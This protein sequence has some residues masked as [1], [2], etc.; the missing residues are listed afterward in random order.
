MIGIESN[1]FFIFCVNFNR[2][3]LTILIGEVYLLSYSKI[4]SARKLFDL[5]CK[6]ASGFSIP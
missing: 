2:E 4:L 5:K 1:G 6:I 3:R